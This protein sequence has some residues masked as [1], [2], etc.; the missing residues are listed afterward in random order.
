MRP[1]T[2]RQGRVLRTIVGFLEREERPPTTRELAGLLRC[3]VKTV[4][5]YILALERKGCI[6]RRDGRIRVAP[7]LRRRGAI[8]IVGRVAA[9][10]PIL[11]VENVEGRLALDSMFSPGEGAFAL[12]VHG[13]SMVGAHIC[14]GD[15]VI[16]RQQPSVEDGE[17]GVAIVNDEATVKR[18]HVTGRRVRLVA[19]N[20]KHR[21]MEFDARS[22]DVRIVGKVIGVVR[23]M[24]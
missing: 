8:P 10:K 11:A 1:L 2:D 4:Y 9:G 16:V 21:A 5:Q 13:D 24:Q 12:M 19:A 22:D 23:R 20:P 18:I 3:H 17:I 6:E 15:H 14:D 7:E